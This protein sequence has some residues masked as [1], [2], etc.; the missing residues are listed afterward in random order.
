MAIDED[1]QNLPAITGTVSGSSLLYVVEALTDY[2]VTKDI[3][4]QEVNADI[5]ALEGVVDSIASFKNKIINGAMNISQR[6]T[7]FDSTTT[8]ANNDNTYLLDRWKLVSDGN[9]I[10]DVSQTFPVPNGFLNSMK[11]TVQTANKKFGFLHPISRINCYNMIKASSSFYARNNTGS[12]I[13]NVRVALVRWNG[14]PDSVGQLVAPGNWGAVDINP[15]LSA[16]WTYFQASNNIPISTTYTRYLFE[17]IPVASFQNIGIFIWINDTDAAINDDLYLS[18]IQVEEG[19]TATDFDFRS[20]YIEEML[21]NYY[22]GQL[23][24]GLQQIGIGQCISGTSALIVV[25]FS[26][27]RIAPTKIN[28][29]PTSFNLTNAG[30]GL[31]AVTT[32]GTPLTST[33]CCQTFLV[34]VAA[35]LAAG[36]STFFTQSAPGLFAE[37]AEI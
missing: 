6:G 1:L 15:T 37:D 11:A 24:S 32:I 34:N 21:C 35:G 3:L 2:K 20:D 18:G 10:V 12:A 33:N 19:A 31:V 29:N 17:N 22:Y 25:K 9:D 5:T 7:T 8:P 14:S 4:L 27:K 16:G 26:H 28:L 36:N 30:G 23:P 13:D